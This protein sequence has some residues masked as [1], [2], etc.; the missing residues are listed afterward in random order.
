MVFS[1]RVGALLLALLAW[2]GLA[3]AMTIAVAGPMAPPPAVGPPPF[4]CLRA[5][6]TEF[7]P[8]E[9]SKVRQMLPQS[10]PLPAGDE[11]KI[12]IAGR[13]EDKAQTGVLTF[14]IFAPGQPIRYYPTLGKVLLYDHMHEQ[15]PTNVVVN[16]SDSGSETHEVHFIEHDF[17]QDRTAGSVTPN[18]DLTRLYTNRSIFYVACRANDLVAWGF[19]PVKTA[20]RGTA[21]AW[22]ALSIAGLYLAAA[23]FVYLRRSGAA[24]KQIEAQ[25]LYRIETLKKWSFLKCLSPIAMTADVF[26]RGSLAKLQILGFTL[27]VAYNLIYLVLWENQLFTLSPSVV[28]LLGIPA[29]GTLG[30]QVATTTRDRLSAENWAWLVS[31]HVL[32]L[33]DP[34]AGKGPQISDLVMS[35]SELDLYK[36]QALTFSLIVGVSMMAAGPKGLGQFTV[37]DT[38]LQILGLSQLVLVGGRFAKPAT[39]GDIDDRLTELRTRLSIVVRAVTTGTDVDET[40]KPL[41]VAAAA[42]AAKG[43]QAIPA[44]VNAAAR[45]VPNAVRRYRDAAG[46]VQV[47]LEA[48]SHRSVETQRLLNPKLQ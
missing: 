2:P 38:L 19:G 28:F 47:L 35:D 9:N 33:N 45:T 27:L 31:R 21:Q 41:A 17:D 10:G 3:P 5:K 8:F 25:K 37:P 13:I 34:G 7:P 32:P 14:R 30:A 4:N 6:I 39:L 36:L 11:S 16:N 18:V 20:S 40:G 46:D 22:A 26:D 29:L 43:A 23:T 24:E 48:M 1:L 42:P 44:D 15:Y 12:V